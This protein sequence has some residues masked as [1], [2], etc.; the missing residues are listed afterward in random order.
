M[1]YEELRNLARFRFAQMKS[2]QTLQATALVHEA[3][4]RL[5][6]AEDHQWNGQ[7]HFFRAAAESMR[8]II[9]DNIRR[10]RTKRHG[11]HLERVEMEPIELPLDADEDQLLELY[12]VLDQLEE[13]DAEVAQ[14]VKLRFFVGLTLPEAAQA[15]GMAERTAKRRWAYARAW[16]FR[17]MAK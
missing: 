12:E 2:D 15:L 11:G 9:I 6:K 3:Y 5:S 10:K 1:V 4:L 7:E 16:L 14:L 13:S 17:R 8:R